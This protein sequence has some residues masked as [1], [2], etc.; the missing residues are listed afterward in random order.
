M[1]QWYSLMIFVKIIGPWGMV[2]CQKLDP[3]LVMKYFGFIILT[4]TVCAVSRAKIGTISKFQWSMVSAY[5]T[6][7]TVDKK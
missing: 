4:Q 5:M 6:P 7:L 3:F 1:G 2:G